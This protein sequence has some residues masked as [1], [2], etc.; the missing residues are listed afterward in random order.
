MKESVDR[1]RK[2]NN[3]EEILRGAEK[4]GNVEKIKIGKYV[5]KDKE[6]WQ[7]ETLK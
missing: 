6:N 7:K 5:E 2:H 3:I 4:R 1:E